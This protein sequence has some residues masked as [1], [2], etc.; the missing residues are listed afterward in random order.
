MQTVKLDPSRLYGFKILR[1]SDTAA[2]A[3]RL[4]SKIGEKSGVKVG[5]KLGSKIGGKVGAKVTA[6]A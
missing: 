2:S 4:G 5:A 3:T 6:P 1:Q